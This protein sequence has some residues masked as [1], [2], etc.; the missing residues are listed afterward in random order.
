MGN[1]EE[2]KTNNIEKVRTENSGKVERE[3]KEKD[4]VEHAWASRSQRLDRR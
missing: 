4:I 2:M 1:I 3:V